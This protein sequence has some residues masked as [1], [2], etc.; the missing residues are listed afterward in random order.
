MIPATGGFLQRDFTVTE[1]PTKTYRMDILNEDSVKGYTDG[2]DAMRQ[3]NYKILNTERYEYVIYPWSYGFE[4]ND[5]FGEPVSYVCPELERRIT[6]A[7][8][9]DTRNTDVT[10][11]EF[12]TSTRHVVKAKFTVHTIFGDYEEEKAVNI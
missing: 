5:L 9:T 11:F 10:D 4:I 6:E 12:D 7:L 2:L 8:L 1:Q 3:A